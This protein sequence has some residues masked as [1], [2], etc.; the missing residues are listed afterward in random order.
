MSASAY[1]T[2]SPARRRQGLL[3]LLALALALIILGITF[4]AEIKDYCLFLWHL[5]QDKDAF[6][7]YIASFGFWAPAVFML[8]QIG[9]VVLAPIPGELTGAVG[10]YIF[11]WPL[12]MLYS[13]IGLTTGSIVIFT[14]GRLLGQPL[15]VRF[16]PKQYLDR[17]AFI[18]EKQGVLTCFIFFI[19]P[20]FPKDY[21]CMMLGMTPIHWRVFLV[22]CALGRIPGTLMLS[23]QGAALYE[24]N[25]WFLL[26]LALASIIL[27]WAA[28][29]WRNTLYELVVR[30]EGGGKIK[31]EP[32]TDE[33]APSKN[34]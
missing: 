24:K 11:G 5:V 7:Q 3:I 2:V 17:F 31:P 20:G 23:L 22:I 25:Y 8:F 30:L 16:V 6:N 10:G 18:M 29:N 27:I 13:T 4:F 28:Y 9:Q 1:D 26:W 21:L 14:L 15:I 32:K 19:I 33:A 12:A 34:G